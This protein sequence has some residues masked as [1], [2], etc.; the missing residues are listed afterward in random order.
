[1][2]PS[3]AP[4]LTTLTSPQDL[5]SPL[6]PWAVALRAMETDR[7]TGRIRE[8]AHRWLELLPPTSFL[9]T[10]V[11]EGFR[12]E[13][14]KWPPRQ[15]HP[16]P[17]FPLLPHHTRAVSEMVVSLLA[18]GILERVHEGLTPHLALYAPMFAVDK[19]GTTTIR[20]IYDARFL[21][22]FINYRKF[23]MENLLTAKDLVREGDYFCKVDLKDAYFHM[24]VHPEHRPLLAFRWH[25]EAY[26]YRAI[27]FGVSP[28]P[29]LFTKLLR[30]VVGALRKRGI[31]CVVY[32]DDLLF[33]GRTKTEAEEAA[34][35]AILLLH[36]LGFLISWKKSILVGVQS[37][38]FLGII[39]DSVKMEFRLST[40]KLEGLRQ[41][42]TTLS[43]SAEPTGRVPTRLLASVLGSFASCIMACEVT[44]LKT[45]A[46]QRCLNLTLALGQGYRGT[47]TLTDPARTELCWWR[48]TL[49]AWNGRT[50]LPRT[51][52]SATELFVSDASDAGWGM[53]HLRGNDRTAQHN[54]QGFWTPEEHPLHN[55]PKE[56]RG[57]AYGL[58]AWIQHLNLHDTTVHVRTDNTV[59]LSYISKQ[60]GRLPDLGAVAEELWAYCLD[61]G[62]TLTADH[63]PGVLNTLADKWS[64]KE[65]GPS[66][67][68]LTDQ[69][70]T[71]VERR[72]GPF[73]VDLFAS[74]TNHRLPRY[75]SRYPDPGATATDAF[76]QDWRGEQSYC[77]P[78]FPVIGQVLRKLELEGGVMTIIVPEWTTQPWWPTLLGLRN[79]RIE[80]FVLPLSALDNPAKS[81][82]LPPTGTVLSVWTLYA[83]IGHPGASRVK[84]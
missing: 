33:M 66:E 37:M 53:S 21:N 19:R 67:C 74:R 50:L 82:A 15:R 81:D 28:A 54:A 18:R 78:P 75:Y 44:R 40:D 13:L 30:P 57:I 58:K 42:A 70:F 51:R 49:T 72:R 20:P 8:R 55:N 6:P 16:P 7:P 31:R 10:A 5:V 62:I 39:I 64:R 69:F 46:L 32:L 43:L 12:L 73:T 41:R 14:L 60:G 23:K 4:V 24:E 38:E 79:P 29:R 22:K 80:M 68:R 84:Q 35:A 48:D 61:K 65:A 3:G 83:P 56:L 26:Q 34:R 63:I 52:A 76:S 71:L 27:P 25:G 1:M 9:T 36:E 77:F 59:A 45:R 47:A 17:Q 2:T 11:V